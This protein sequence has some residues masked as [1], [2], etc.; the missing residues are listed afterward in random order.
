[1]NIFRG[2]KILL[3]LFVV[4]SLLVYFGGDLDED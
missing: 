3:I 4:I 2:M 1:M